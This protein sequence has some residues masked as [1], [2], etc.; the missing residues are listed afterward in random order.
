[1]VFAGL[2]AT[3]RSARSGQMTYIGS[4]TGPTRH[5]FPAQIWVSVRRA[6]TAW[7]SFTSLAIH[8]LTA[9]YQDF[10][11]TGEPNTDCIHLLDSM[12]DWPL[13][14]DITTTTLGAINHP[15]GLLTNIDDHLLISTAAMR[16]GV[17]DPALVLTSQLLHAYK[18]HLAFYQRAVC[19]IGP[20]T[21]IASSARDVRGALEAHLTCIRIARPGH[22][23]DPAGPS[24]ILTIDDIAAVSAKLNSS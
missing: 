5:P 11:L 18:P 14:P 10:Q 15:L 9:A 16:L 7:R 8:A 4:R 2:P 17:F 1:M 19:R 6:A 13:W 20:I 3:Q 23:V 21:H 22:A 12:A 24:P